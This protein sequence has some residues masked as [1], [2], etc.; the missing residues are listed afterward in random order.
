MV[1]DLRCDDVTD[2]IH[3]HTVNPFELAILFPIN[4]KFPEVVPLAIKHVHSVLGHDED[5]VFSWIYRHPFGIGYLLTNFSRTRHMPPVLPD[6]FPQK[7]TAEKT[8]AQ[9]LEESQT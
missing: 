1:I 5:V 2:S 9:S 7:R 8:F 6:V 3:R 4:P